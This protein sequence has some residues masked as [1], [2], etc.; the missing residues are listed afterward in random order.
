MPKFFTFWAIIISFLIILLSIIFNLPYWTILSC[1]T[2]IS[3]ICI[4]GSMLLLY[5]NINELS[6]EN[7]EKLHIYNVKTHLIPLITVI[8]VFSM[9][10][11]KDNQYSGW[12]YLKSL[13]IPI[14]ISIIYECFINFDY[15]LTIVKLDSTEFEIQYY[16]VLIFLTAFIIYT[17][18]YQIYAVNS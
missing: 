17:I 18:T 15:Y 11:K 16:K 8:F 4:A 9:I 2:F 7:Q 12:N 10:R 6:K 3:S 13:I 5:R 14:I 1:I